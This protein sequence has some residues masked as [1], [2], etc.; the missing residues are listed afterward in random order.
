MRFY[1]ITADLVVSKHIIKGVYATTPEEAISKVEDDAMADSFKLVS[2]KDMTPV[3]EIK[4][5]PVR[6]REKK[7]DDR[8]VIEL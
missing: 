8:V 7:V 2:V 4:V 1:V 5:T 3:E 6:K